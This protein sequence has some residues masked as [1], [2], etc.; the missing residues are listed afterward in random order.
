MKNKKQQ[1][2]GCILFWII[3]SSS[4]AAQNTLISEM[5][6][7]KWNKIMPGIWKASFGK[8][9]LNPIEYANSPNKEAINSLGDTPVPIKLDSTFYQLTKEMA[10]VRLPLDKSENIFGLGLEFNGLNRRKNVYELKVDH[11]GG[12]K[13][14]THAPVPFYISNKGYGVLINSA[15]RVKIYVGIGNRKDS[16]KPESVDRTTRPKDWIARPTSDAVEASVQG[17]GLEIYIFTGN[18]SL[19]VV[20]RYNLFCGGGALPPKW[21]L[22]FW[23][24]MHTKSSE[25]DVLSEIKEFNS[26]NFPID[27]LGLEPGW[28]SFAYP[29]SYDWDSNRFPNPA[30][31]VNKLKKQN[32]RINL[33]ENPYVSS[34]STM[35]DSIKPYT[36]SHT[37]WLGEV[38]DYTLPEA[39]SI[40]MNHHK[41]N[42]LNIG[43]SGYK[44]DEVDGY[45]VWLW[46]DHATFPS[47]NNAVEIR[48]IYGLI[49]Q[50]T[51]SDY[52]R[53]LNQRTY[54]LIRSSYLGASNHNFVLYSD[55]YNHKGYVTALINS[56]F[57]GILWTPEIRNAKTSE[58]WIRRFQTVCFSPLM[59]LNAWASSK[60]PWSFPEVTDMVR[61]NI[62]LRMKLLPYLYTAFYEYTSKGIPPFRAMTLEQGYLIENQDMG[63]TL[64]GERNPYAEKK[65]V[66]VTDQYMMGPSI[67]VAPVF[68][69]QKER[70]VVLPKGNWYDFYTGEYVGNGEEIKIKTHL[71]KIPLFVK[72][73]A[74]IPMLFDVKDKGTNQALQVRYYGTK[75]GNYLMYNDDGNTYNYKNGDYTL[76]E[77]KVFKDNQ[78]KLKGTRKVLNNSKYAYGDID[79]V[80]MTKKDETD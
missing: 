6:N 63:G 79:W 20:Q 46:P 21:G 61:D 72:D 51:F 76:E 47:G 66:E 68:V 25:E 34:N 4:I 45:D 73:G 5:D 50:K 39:Q 35:F 75:K 17:E 18:T 57:S 33:W 31:F 59:M 14:H 62:N 40:L 65:L 70:T 13:G 30:A 49:L 44:L 60:K 38:P 77:L 54:G 23:H 32:I 58:E 37:V 26:H 16:H 22:G 56:S 1:I 8:S 2:W 12:V 15:K 27:V 42:H 64:D 19:E 3:A 43:V 80:W 10:I 36:G 24:R 55:H 71:S 28:Q 41:R 78:N 29:C 52:F 69:K 67:L 74:I 53:K 7:L 48:Q 11:Y 9:G